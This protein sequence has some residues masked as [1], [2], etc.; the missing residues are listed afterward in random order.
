MWH[1]LNAPGITLVLTAA[2]IA[3]LCA[4][5]ART[6]E[7]QVAP[8][9]AVTATQ[10]APS[11]VDGVLDDEIW[12]TAAV[13]TDFRR[14]DGKAPAGKAR[15]LV[16]QDDA[17]LY[18]AIESFEDEKTLAA[19]VADVKEHDGKDMWDDDEVEVFL[20]PGGAA[21][22]YYQ[23]AVNSRGVAWDAYHAVPG[24]SDTSWS[25]RY[26]CAAKVGKGSWV[27]EIA[28]PWSA[29][30]A[31]LKFADTWAFEALITRQAAGEELWL[32]PIKGNAH[33]PAKFGALSGLV[34]KAPAG[35]K[36]RLPIVREKPDPTKEPYFKLYEARQYK[37]KDGK[38]LLYR[39]VKPEP[40]DPAVKRPL[41]IYLHGGGLRGSN[42]IDQ[43]PE[44]HVEGLR[45]VQQYGAILVVPQCPATTGWTFEPMTRPA[46]APD[47][48]APAAPP[49]TDPPQSVTPLKLLVE[50]LPEL[51]K[52][53][54]L[55]MDRIYIAGGSMGGGGVYR[56]IE[57]HSD[58]FAAAIIMCGGGADPSKAPIF[59]HLPMWLF[60][61]DKDKVVPTQTSR[62]MV[63]AL[64]KAGGTPR[65]SE[66]KGYKHDLGTSVSDEKE[67]LPWLFA[68]K[69]MP[70]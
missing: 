61:G 65:Y 39:L 66:L 42:N 25:P 54:N 67:L 16:A 2:A 38:V 22:G 52:E 31:T 4:C 48:P 26:E 29:F 24:N 17:N 56:M 69:R 59:A 36:E 51:Q 33:Q 27:V 50:L 58:L 43:V 8:T 37:D 47:A 70:R 55:D 45:A 28:L 53:F 12:K 64:K 13:F 20:A 5:A 23:I 1:C 60:H 7:A 15:L 41:V 44:F 68:Q 40:L 30:D 18:L 19:L 62:D 57:R 35:A 6:S 10:A 63:A 49:A 32:A 34:G 46:R 14:A 9:I 11:R 3:L 21:Q